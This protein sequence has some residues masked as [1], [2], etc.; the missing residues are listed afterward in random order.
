MFV[1][2]WPDAADSN[3]TWPSIPWIAKHSST[4]AVLN[5]ATQGQSQEVHSCDELHA[6]FAEQQS[7]GEINGMLLARQ[8]Y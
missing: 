5:S 2:A 1:I 3:H 4:V 8:Q 7:N 6:R